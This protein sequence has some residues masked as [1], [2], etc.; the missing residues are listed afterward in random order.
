MDL[1]LPWN[2]WNQSLPESLEISTWTTEELNLWLTNFI[3]YYNTV[4]NY[5]ESQ[6]EPGMVSG[7]IPLDIEQVWLAEQYETMGPEEIFADIQQNFPQFEDFRLWLNY[8][9]GTSGLVTL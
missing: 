8:F 6:L 4:L 2:E 3:T 1:D 7:N 5:T 9:F